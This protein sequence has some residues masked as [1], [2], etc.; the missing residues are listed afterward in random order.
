[1]IFIVGEYSEFGSR[2]TPVS[3]LF[4]T[5]APCKQEVLWLSGEWTTILNKEGLIGMTVAVKSYP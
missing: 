4:T 2:K 3:D 5:L 1:M